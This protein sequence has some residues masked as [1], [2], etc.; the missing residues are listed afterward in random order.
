MSLHDVEVWSGTQKWY[1]KFIVFSVEKNGNW[2]HYNLKVI[3]MN[4]LKWILIACVIGSWP[5]IF[6]AGRWVEVTQF[7]LFCFGS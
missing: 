3:F 7:K 5:L 2:T 6:F 1:Y 4:Y